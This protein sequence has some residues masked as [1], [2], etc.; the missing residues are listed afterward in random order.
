VDQ[1][2]S[3]PAGVYSAV[4]VTNG[5]EPELTFVAAMVLGC[6][7]GRACCARAARARQSSRED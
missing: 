6:W 4:G 5:D 2:L 3:L 1:P 7:R